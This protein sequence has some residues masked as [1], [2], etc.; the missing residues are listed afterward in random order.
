MPDPLEQPAFHAA[1]AL[2]AALDQATARWAPADRLA[3]ALVGAAVD[4][5]AHT[6]SAV[7]RPPGPARDAAGEK[8]RG[9]TG[10]IAILVD[11]AH[12]RGQLDPRRARMLA[13]ASAGLWQTVRQAIGRRRSGPPVAASPGRPALPQ[14]TYARPAPA[15]SAPA[16]PAAVRPTSALPPLRPALQ[17]RVAS[18]A[19]QLD[20]IPDPLPPAP[21]GPLRNARR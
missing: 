6:L 10:R 1:R 17:A 19:E 9:T 18:P 2:A 21:T 8:L 5:L 7:L 14:P 15:R 4:A 13:L 16:R 11:V 3:Q 20:T 12:D